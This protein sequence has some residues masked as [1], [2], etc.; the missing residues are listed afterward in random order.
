M[1]NSLIAE[2]NVSLEMDE[3]KDMTP[4]FLAEEQKLIKIIQAFETI[5]KSQEWKTLQELVFDG[6]IPNL[7]RMIEL[8]IKKQPINTDKIHSLN[9]QLAWAEKFLNF[10]K[11]AEIYRTQLRSI[12]EKLN[13]KER[14]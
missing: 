4:T 7:K 3:P 14:K 6:Q 5:D 8:E 11:L 13:A 2:M 9:G 1:N 12:K 10:K